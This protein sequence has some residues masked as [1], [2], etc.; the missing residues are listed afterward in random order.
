MS[1]EPAIPVAEWP[2][3]VQ[4]G[5]GDTVQLMADLT[6]S[7]WRARRSGA[8]FSGD[9]L[10]NAFLSAIGPEGTLLI[11]TFDHDL[12]SGDRFDIRRTRSLSGALASIAL[13]REDVRRTPNPLHSF[14]VFGRAAAQLAGTDHP[15]SFGEDSPFGFL[16]QEHGVLVALDL[17]LNDAF[18]YVHHVEEL[19]QVP[20]RRWQDL[21]IKYTDGSGKTRWKRYRSFAKR[22]GGH[23]DLTGLEPMLESAGALTRGAIAAMPFIRVDLAAAHEV[24]RQ[25]IRDNGSRAFHSFTWKRWFRDHAK[26]ILNRMRHKTRHQ[27]IAHAARTHR[28]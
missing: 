24:V 5:P 20:H 11:P 17:P 15:S 9:E 8:D 6:R 22:P 2:S 10:I 19:E 16:R 26:R 28:G 18:T 12:R 4:V 1:R 13:S 14:A 27:R 7:A 3:L 23:T 25:E 21:R